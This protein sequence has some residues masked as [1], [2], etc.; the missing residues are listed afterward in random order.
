M[1]GVVFFGVV[2]MF[3]VVTS[4]QLL[5]VVWCSAVAVVVVG[6]VLVVVYWSCSC[7]GVVVVL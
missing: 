5:D 2:A 3:A 1:V 6:L 7:T 4:P